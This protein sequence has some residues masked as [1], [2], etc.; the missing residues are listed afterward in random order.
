MLNCV[1]H[2]LALCASTSEKQADL[3]YGGTGGE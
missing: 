1:G 3:V 2:V